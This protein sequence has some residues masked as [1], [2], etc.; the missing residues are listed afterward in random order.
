MSKPIRRFSLSDANRNLL[1]VDIDG[2]LQDTMVSKLI[3]EIDTVGGYATLKAKETDLDKNV[4]RYQNITG[5]KEYEME[6]TEVK[7]Y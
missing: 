4:F 3:L 7:Y 1:L 6:V 2:F 5:E